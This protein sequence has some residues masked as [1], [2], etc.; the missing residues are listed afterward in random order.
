MPMLYGEGSKAFRRLQEEILKK[1][2]ADKS[3][4]VV[5]EDKIPLSK[6]GSRSYLPTH[7]ASLL[8]PH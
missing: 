2:Q 3:I 6:E 5:D 1:F 4:L 7:L 8:M